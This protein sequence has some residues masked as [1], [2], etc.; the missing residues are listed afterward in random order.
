MLTWEWYDDINTKVVFLHLLL[1]ANYEQQKWHGIT[2]ERGQRVASYGKLAQETRLSVQSVR[3]AIKHLISTGELTHQTTAEYGLFTVS[4]YDKYQDLTPIATVDQQAANSQPTVDQQQRNKAKKDKKEEIP[5]IS[6]KGDANTFFES[7]WKLYPNKKGKG[8]VSDKKKHELLSVGHE[9]L[10]RCIERYNTMLTAE[11]WRQPQDGGTFFNR[12]Y[13]DYLDSEW[14]EP[15]PPVYVTAAEIDPAGDENK[16]KITE[17][18]TW[19]EMVD[20]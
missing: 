6:P 13:L 15:A 1:T 14:Q 4:N 2:I 10:V 17:D 16:R 5:P 18:M 20:T 12:G 8:R 3:T 19:A 11:T 7:V 9:Q